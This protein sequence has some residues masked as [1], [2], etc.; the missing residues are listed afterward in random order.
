M[1]MDLVI[2]TT[3]THKAREIRTLLRRLPQFEVYSLVDFPEYLPPKETGNTFEE[4]ALIKGKHAAETLKK[5]VIADDSGLVVPALGGMPGILSAR[6]AGDG[7]TDRD[8]RKKLLKEMEGFEEFR[9]S[10]HFECCLVLCSPM[11]IAKTFKGICEGTITTQERGGNGFGYDP[12]FLKHDYNQTFSELDEAVKNQ[13][14]HRA[15]ALQK[16]IL[17]LQSSSIDH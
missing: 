2:A 9:R 3:N 6:Y 12:L 4:N 8:N 10:A 16:L 13:I 14:S 11:G 15:K 17:R 7:A 5:W 1:P